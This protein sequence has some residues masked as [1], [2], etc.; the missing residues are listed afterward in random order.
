MN[1]H[2]QG[3]QAPY[4]DV[5]ATKLPIVFALGLPIFTR[6]VIPDFSDRKRHPF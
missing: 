6:H 4:Q 5:F 1:L 2:T 3:G